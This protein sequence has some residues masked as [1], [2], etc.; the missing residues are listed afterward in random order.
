MYLAKLPVVYYEHFTASQIVYIYLVADIKGCYYIT[1][2][3]IYGQVGTQAR[4]T[5]TAIWTSFLLQYSRIRVAAE[6]GGPANF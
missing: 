6:V 5:C 2:A 3:Y 1:V 4:T